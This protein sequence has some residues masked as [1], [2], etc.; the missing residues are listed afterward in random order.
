MRH[1]LLS[2]ALVAFAAVTFTSCD[3]DEENSKD[4]AIMVILKMRGLDYWE[5]IGDAIQRKCAEKD[6]KAVI[7][8]TDSDA[9]YQSQLDALNEM[10]AMDNNYR[11]IIVVPIYSS[12]NHKVENKVLD[13]ASKLDVPIIILDTP[14]NE[15]ESPLAGKYRT[16]VGTDNEAAGAVLARNVNVDAKNI[17]SVRSKASN[18]GAM[19]YNGFCSVKGETSIWEAAESEANDIEQQLKNFP[20]ATDIVYFNGSLADGDKVIDI[21]RKSGKGL[22]S[23][24]A[25]T[26]TLKALEEGDVVKGVLAQQTFEMGRQAVEAVFNPNVK[27]PLYIEPIFITKD[28]INSDEVRPFLDFHKI[29]GG[30]TGN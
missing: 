12:D 24:D 23:F 11:G 17:L 30:L 27:N 13:V 8:Y 22:Y 18:A 20:D 5:Q 9:D 10:E 21:L 2:I 1:F 15:E 19:R 29:V 28:N 25:F 3:D 6:V 26:S 7:R 14:V 4:D 16:Y